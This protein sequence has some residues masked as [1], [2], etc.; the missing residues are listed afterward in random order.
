MEG[1]CNRVPFLCWPY[2]VDQIYNK[3]YIYDELNV[4]LGLNLDENGL[5]SWWEIKKKLD[6]LLSDENIRSRSLKLKEEAM[7]NQINEGRS[8][9]NLN[10]VVKV[11][12]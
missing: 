1:L 6:Q 10:K 2:F 5:V 9:E 7:H 4:G 12:S 11:S 3:T 8:L